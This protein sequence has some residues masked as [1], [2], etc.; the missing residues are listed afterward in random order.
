M[1]E[2]SG[3][4]RSPFSFNAAFGKAAQWISIQCGRGSTFILACVAIVVWA[5]TGPMFHY[6]DTWQ[7]VIN[8][9]TTIVTFLMV[10]LIQNTQNRDMSA[11]HLKLDELIRV[12]ESARNKLIDMENLTEA[13]LKQLKGSFLR[14]ATDETGAAELQDAAEKLDLAEGKIDE[15]KETISV[16]ASGQA[17]RP[18]GAA[19]QA[20]TPHKAR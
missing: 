6:S 4:G 5:V 8:T 2:T 17:S 1:G 16:V 7:L 3:H 13:E 9:G 10:F 18:R 14:L 20:F 19:T 12:S 11:L 15:A